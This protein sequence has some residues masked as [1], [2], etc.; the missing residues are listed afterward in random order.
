MIDRR[1]KEIKDRIARLKAEHSRV[2]ALLDKKKIET[3]ALAAGIDK[4]KD[5]PKLKAQVGNII[6]QRAQEIKALLDRL[7]EL[8]TES[9]EIKLEMKKTFSA[10]KSQEKKRRETVVH[11]AQKPM[12]IAASETCEKALD[13]ALSEVVPPQPKEAARP[14]PVK[15]AEKKAEVKIEKPAK[16]AP[17]KDLYDQAASE[18][19][20]QEAFLKSQSS[21][22]IGNF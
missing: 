4:Y 8:R 9:Q 17:A 10:I 3:E 13:Q 15:K 12:V 11:V 5:N 7:A 22:F 18:A 19:Q 14:E 6:K 1:I 16:K 20:A 2:A 21:K